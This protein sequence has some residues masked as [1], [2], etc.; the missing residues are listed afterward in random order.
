MGSINVHR[1]SSS[2]QRAYVLQEDLTV[3]K[4]TK[5]PGSNQFKNQNAMG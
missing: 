2:P 4:L 1:A 3:N 5:I